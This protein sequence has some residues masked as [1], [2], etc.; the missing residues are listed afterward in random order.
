MLGRKKAGRCNRK[1]RDK[2][3]STVMLIMAMFITTILGAN[4]LENLWRSEERFFY[5]VEDMESQDTIENNNIES[6]GVA[7]RSAGKKRS[8]AKESSE[9]N[10]SGES[11]IDVPYIDQSNGY[12]TG[13]EVVSAT[14]LLQYYGYGISVDDFIDNYLDMSLLEEW[15]GVLIG[16]NP[17]KVFIGDPRSI[18]S[19]GCF[20]PVIEKSLNRIIDNDMIVK[21]TT[22]TSI[23]TLVKDY[24]DKEIPVL[25]WAT[26]NLGP[27]FQSMEW[28]LRDTGET[29]QW[30][31]NE[32]CMVLVGYDEDSYYFND[33]YESNGLI[34]YDKELVEMRYKEMGMQSV[35]IIE[36]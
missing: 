32:H 14:M 36:S 33:P 26:I 20:A 35:V 23:E 1:C 29:Y 9:I 27:S 13:C 3:I 28:Q 15:D 4:V 10:L 18:Y 6:T 16:D 7:I 21:N 24:I 5:E 19:Y 11:I 25:F 8:V 2:K 34:D 22:G 30:Q 17:E 12:P 31:A